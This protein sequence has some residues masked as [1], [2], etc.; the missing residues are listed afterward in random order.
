MQ[1]LIS[2][3]RT[4]E[5]LIYGACSYFKTQIYYAR[6]ISSESV[7]STL[8]KLIVEFAVMI[9]G[10]SQVRKTGAWKAGSAR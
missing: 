6:N 1:E 7:A 4:F 5:D 8:R 9:V 10:C 3:L 2:H